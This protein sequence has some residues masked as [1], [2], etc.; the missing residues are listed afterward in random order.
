MLLLTKVVQNNLPTF[1][2]AMDAAAKIQQI[3]KKEGHNI[4][5]QIYLIQEQTTT[6]ET[7]DAKFVNQIKQQLQWQPFS[8]KGV[9]KS[10]TYAPN[11]I[12]SLTMNLCSMSIATINAFK[13]DVKNVYGDKTEEEWHT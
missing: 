11:L 13:E 3:T 1:M 7:S 9:G 4:N 12:F 5:G 8:V 6:L 10:L 2:D